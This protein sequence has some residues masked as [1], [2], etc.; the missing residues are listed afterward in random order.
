MFRGLP[1]VS[2]GEEDVIPGMDNENLTTDDADDND[3]ERSKNPSMAFAQ[4]ERQLRLLPGCCNADRALVECFLP[5]WA[6]KAIHVREVYGKSAAR[7]LLCSIRSQPVCQPLHRKRAHV[8]GA[9]ARRQGAGPPSFARNDFRIDA[10]PDR[11]Q[12]T[13]QGKAYSYLSR[14]AAEQ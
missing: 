9:G 13:G 2:F 3:W 7:H 12:V 6:A 4:S 11:G 5:P 10:Q 1:I 8:A 14:P